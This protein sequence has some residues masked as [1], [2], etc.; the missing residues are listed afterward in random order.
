[1]KVVF[2]LRYGFY[3]AFMWLMLLPSEAAGVWHF[4][5]AS[6]LALFAN[7]LNTIKE[8]L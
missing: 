6:I 1:M 5:L 8:K 3:Y 4:T 7:Q 2:I